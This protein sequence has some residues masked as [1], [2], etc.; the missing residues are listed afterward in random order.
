[1]LK[2]CV[3]PA[4]METAD[5]LCFVEPGKLHATQMPMHNAL[6]PVHPTTMEQLATA[7]HAACSRDKPA[8]TVPVQVGEVQSRSAV[9][10]E[11]HIATLSQDTECRPISRGLPDPINALTDVLAESGSEDE[12]ITWSCVC[13]AVLACF[14]DEC[15]TA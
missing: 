1:M 3:Q 8:T 9:G 5:S 11:D 6:Q 12:P 14:L 2:H 13:L 10:P 15:G 7:P 4:S